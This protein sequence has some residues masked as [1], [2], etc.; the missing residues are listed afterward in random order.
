[1]RIP[2]TLLKKKTLEACNYIKNRLQHSC[3]SVKF[4]KYLRTPILKN[5][6]ERLL[7]FVPR[8]LM[9]PENFVH[10][11]LN[12]TRSMHLEDAHNL[13]KQCVWILLIN[14]ILLI[15]KWVTSHYS[16]NWICTYRGTNIK[17]YFVF[18]Y[19][20]EHF[21]LSPYIVDTV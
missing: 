16:S 2:A 8:M 13:P 17:T 1:M 4:A 18:R 11:F 19:F 10:A 14:Y 5:I 3:F 7:L 6:W 12:K 20:H 9:L 15:T 21:P